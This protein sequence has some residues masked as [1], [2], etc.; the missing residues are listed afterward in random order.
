MVEI[1]FTKPEMGKAAG[2]AK[3]AELLCACKKEIGLNE[4]SC[5]LEN[6]KQLEDNLAK[7][8]SQ[9]QLWT[10]N[11]GDNLVG[12]LILHN[13]TVCSVKLHEIMYIVVDPN[14]RCRGIGPTLVRYIQAKRGVRGLHA[15]A[16]NDHSEHMLIKY[17]FEPTGDRSASGHP[18]LFWER[19]PRRRFNQ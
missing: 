7:E 17:G 2:A 13:F 18:K 11:K 6:R 3:L 12:L 16:R 1:G 8:C 14:F 10:I 15:E 9:N 4:E 19:R 5:T